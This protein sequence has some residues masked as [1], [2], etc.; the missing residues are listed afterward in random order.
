MFAKV[1]GV[2]TAIIIFFLYFKWRGTEPVLET[3]LG[4]L[5]AL[6]GGYWAWRTTVRRLERLGGDG[7]AAGKTGEGPTDGAPRP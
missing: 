7:K 2:V 4:I 1:I 5:L 3:M 6:L